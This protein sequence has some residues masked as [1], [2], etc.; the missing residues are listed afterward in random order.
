MKHRKYRVGC[1]TCG[2]KEGHAVDCPDGMNRE[3][4]KMWFSKRYNRPV[5]EHRP[6]HLVGSYAHRME[7]V[8]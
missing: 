3:D 7:C 4:F 5:C 8:R 1:Q 2:H 6:D